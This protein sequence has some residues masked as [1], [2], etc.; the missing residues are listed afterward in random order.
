M[1]HVRY[2]M[3]LSFLP[4]GN[5]MLIIANLL[6]AS[7]NKLAALFQYFHTPWINRTPIT[8]HIYDGDVPTN[9]NLEGWHSCFASSV[10]CH[11][12]NIWLL[13]SKIRKEQA[14]PKVCNQ[15]ILIGQIV[16]Q[17]TRLVTSA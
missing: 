10:R 1:E 3:A 9:N 5:I 2:L 6:C 15:Q 13:I 11:H 12:P 14:A 4:R 7:D 8:W 16:S 17:S